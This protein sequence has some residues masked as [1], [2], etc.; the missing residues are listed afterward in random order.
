MDYV[1]RRDCQITDVNGKIMFIERDAVVEAKKNP[2]KGCFDEI[3]G[4]E[5]LDFITASEEELH[6]AKWTFAEAKQAVGEAF[7][8]EIKKREG[9]KKSDVIS[10]ILDARFRN[11]KPA[12]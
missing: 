2:R 6:A 11:D 1:C 7:G 4:S 3:G 5:E 9:D 12:E 8:V 10:K